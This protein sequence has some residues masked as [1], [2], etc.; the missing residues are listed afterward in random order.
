MT[1]TPDS[2]HWRSLLFVPGSRPDRFAKAAGAETDLVCIDLEDA[3]APGDKDAA[4]EA[5]LAYL[6]S[7]KDRDRLL[8]L[9]VNAVG[10]EAGRKD[11]DAIA[12]AAGIDFVMVPKPSGADDISVVHEAYGHNRI[13]AV[14]ESARGIQN[15][16]AIADHP[17]VVAAI[18]GAIDLAADIGC[19]LSWEAHLYGR[20]RCALAFG[21]ARKKLFDVPY[22]DVRDEE[23][24]IEST[25]RA[26][27]LGIY[28]RAAIHPAQL[29]GI[30][31]ALAPTDEEVQYAERVMAAY[32]A[33]DT[34]LTLL[35]GKM[36]ELPVIKSAQRI[37][38]A[39]RH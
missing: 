5:T 10:T 28:A 33:S 1:D 29:A 6:A 24:L 31:K 35:D 20:S 27:K 23:G 11:F 15:V 7:T 12:G 21:A 8:G 36:V 25:R 2:L 14:L 30:H 16:E 19:D 9:R 32:E 17:G 18:Y 34:G 38:A 3:V 26:K 37:L 13:I 4:R 22:L 39:A